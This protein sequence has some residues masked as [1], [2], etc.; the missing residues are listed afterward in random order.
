MSLKNKKLLK[1]L[2]QTIVVISAVNIAYASDSTHHD[3]PSISS[4]L[5]PLVNSS[6][7]VAI[8]IWAYKKYIRQELVNNAG[9][10]QG[11]LD[12]SKKLIT[13]A[14]SY[15]KEVS[16]RH[17]QLN[18][19]RS[20]IIA[21]YQSEGEKTGRQLIQNAHLQLKVIEEGVERQVNSELNQAKNEIKLEVVTE[22]IKITRERI[23]SELSHEQDKQLRFRALDYL[24]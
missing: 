6:I 21:E 15:L 5:W 3:P 18:V 8:L 12:A 4:L 22:A 23:R 10:L 24:H 14:E 17:H 16:E 11:L 19:E 20:K 9:K 2:L 13:T 1:A 7:Y